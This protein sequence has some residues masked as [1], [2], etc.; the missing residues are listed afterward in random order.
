MGGG[1]ADRDGQGCMILGPG[2]VATGGVDL[3]IDI[4][5]CITCSLAYCVAA[6]LALCRPWLQGR[7]VCFNAIIA[8]QAATC[9]SS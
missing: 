8:A 3:M 9:L 5:G 7:S 4:H 2:A 6:V 1:G